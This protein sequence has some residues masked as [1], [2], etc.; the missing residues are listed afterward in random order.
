[1]VTRCKPGYCLFHYKSGAPYLP[2]D[3]SYFRAF[4]SSALDCFH[5]N[6]ALIFTDLRNTQPKCPTDRPGTYLKIHSEE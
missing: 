2:V 4:F 5:K 6:V 1:L 3:P